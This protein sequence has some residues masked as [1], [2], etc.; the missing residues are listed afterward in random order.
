MNNDIVWYSSH[1]KD[2]K[3]IDPYV[4][5]VLL[6]YQSALGIALEEQIY[7]IKPGKG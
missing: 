7:T 5:T 2:V 3:S 1:Q 6:F 4:D